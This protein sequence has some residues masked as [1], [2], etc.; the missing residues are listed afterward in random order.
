MAKAKAKGFSQFNAALEGRDVLFG[1]SESLPRVVELDVEGIQPN[2]DQPR[3]TFDEGRLRELADSIRANGLIQPIV[4]AR[5]EGAGHYIVVAGERRLRAHQMLERRTIPA[6]IT[7]GNPEVLALIENIQRENLDPLEEADAYALMMERH[8]YSQTELGRI[9]G[10]KQNTVS[11]ALSLRRLSEE[12]KARYRTSDTRP[13]E[14]VLVEIARETD[15]ARQ[16]ELLAEALE[17][18]LGV[19]AVRARRASSP[20]A[21]KAVG[22]PDKTSARGEGLLRSLAVAL[23][24][25]RTEAGAGDFPAGSPALERL[26]ELKAALDESLAALLQQQ[27]ADPPKKRRPKGP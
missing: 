27:H 2:P 14:N 5:V 18:R 26:R 15:A 20:P 24:R 23:H 8:G 21:A 3:K 7:T 1:V 19:R 4:V 25:A 10:K 12:V 16:L 13:G 11:E 17:F 6:I 22:T 9:V